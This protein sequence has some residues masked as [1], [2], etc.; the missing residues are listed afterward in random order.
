M[1]ILEGQF[2][3]ARHGVSA[4]RTFSYLIF[5]RIQWFSMGAGNCLTPGNIWQCLETVLMVT[6]G[7]EVLLA[8]SG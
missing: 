6:A 4:F 7:E 8:S 3:C 1:D 2:F 5:I